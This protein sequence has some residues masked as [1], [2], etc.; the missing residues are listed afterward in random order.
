MKSND[1]DNDFI[2]NFR[3]IWADNGDAI[4]FH[5]TGTGSTHTEYSFFSY[6]IT[7]DGKRG[8]LGNFKH[9]Y[10]TVT[11]FYNQNF[12]DFEK[13]KLVELLLG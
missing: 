10:K 1:E 6:S 8:W 5:Y 2:H 4:S 12:W 9:K 13:M 11:R 3:N 7:R